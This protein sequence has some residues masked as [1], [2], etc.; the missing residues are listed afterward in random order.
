MSTTT[1]TICPKPRRPVQRSIRLSEDP[2]VF[3]RGS[4]FRNRAWDAPR[5]RFWPKWRR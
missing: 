3:G 1:T 4:A 2:D 5:R